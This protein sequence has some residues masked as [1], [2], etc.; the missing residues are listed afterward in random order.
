MLLYYCT[1]LPGSH[2]I[3]LLYLTVWQAY[4]CLVVLETLMLETLMP[5]RRRHYATLMRSKPFDHSWLEEYQQ[6]QAGE[7]YRLRRASGVR[8]GVPAAPCQGGE[9]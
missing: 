4:C 6:R 9:V 3:V 2:A 1:S 7:E 5:P 8:G